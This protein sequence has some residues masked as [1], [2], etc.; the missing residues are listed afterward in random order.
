MDQEI[1]DVVNELDEVVGQAS[2][3]AAHKDPKLL[4]RCVHFTL[5]DVQTGNI[6]LTQRGPNKKTDPEKYCFSGEHVIAGELYEEAVVRGTTEELGFV[7]TTWREVGTH[8]FTYPSHAE[9]CKFFLIDW[10]SQQL[11]WSKDDFERL[12]WVPRIADAISQY[13]LSETSAFWVAKILSLT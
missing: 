5:I 6:L 10:N 3:E 9:I 2:R 4:H 13:A 11:I 8:L 1:V 7:P 12:V